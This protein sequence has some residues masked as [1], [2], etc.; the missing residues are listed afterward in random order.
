MDLIRQQADN[1]AVDIQGLASYIITT[2]GKLC[3][4]VRDEEI[5][6]LHKNT[7]N[8]VTLFRYAHILDSRHLEACQCCDQTFIS[9]DLTWNLQEFLNSD[10]FCEVLLNHSGSFFLTHQGDF[11]CAGPNEGRYGQLYIR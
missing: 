10:L 5:K 4:P 11:P 6:K 8:I 9:R 1:D 3:A 7:D 2:M